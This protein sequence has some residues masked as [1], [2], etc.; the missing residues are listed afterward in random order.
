M[1]QV[2]S[3]NFNISCCVRREYIYIYIYIYI[4]CIYIFYI[5]TQ[6]DGLDKTKKQSDVTR[7]SY[8]ENIH[9]QYNAQFFNWNLF[10]KLEVLKTV[11]MK[12]I[13][14]LVCDTV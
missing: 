12:K 10:S 13:S 14:L 3:V 9:K 5:V 11:A 7:L 6:R 2:N 1:L 4:Y 8:E